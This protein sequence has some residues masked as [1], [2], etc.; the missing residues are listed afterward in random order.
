RWVA[1]DDFEA[2]IEGDANERVI[3]RNLHLYYS[4]ADP[5]GLHAVRSAWP[6]ILENISL[7]EDDATSECPIRLMLS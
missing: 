6:V 4:C 5:T 1:P 2:K 7:F 3:N